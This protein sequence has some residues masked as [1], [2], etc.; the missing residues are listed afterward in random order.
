MIQ[1]CLYALSKRRHDRLV[2]AKFLYTAYTRYVDVLQKNWN[3]F[4]MGMKFQSPCRENR[5]NLQSR[6]LK[7]YLAK[8]SP[9]EAMVYRASCD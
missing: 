1:L 6:L 7:P 3:Q 5:S 4:G 2:Q 8:R 9:W